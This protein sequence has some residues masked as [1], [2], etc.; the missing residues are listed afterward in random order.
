MAVRRG[1]RGSR[2]VV[3]GGGGATESVESATWD[4]DVV[5]AELVRVVVVVPFFVPIFFEDASFPTSGFWRFFFWRSG[6]FLVEGFEGVFC[7]P[8]VSEGLGVSAALSSVGSWEAEANG[9]PLRTIPLE[10]S[11]LGTGPC[12]SWA[13]SRSLFHRSTLVMAFV[14]MSA[15]WF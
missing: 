3:A 7:V 15:I 5:P 14:N 1:L 9:A 12:L 11:K 13:R 8:V 6:E 10:L 2:V 4:S